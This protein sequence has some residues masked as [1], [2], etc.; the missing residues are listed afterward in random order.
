MPLRNGE[1]QVQLLE[2]HELSLRA[3][4]S[5]TSSGGDI[6]TR[7]NRLMAD[8]SSLQ[9]EFGAFQATFATLAQDVS[10][11]KK[12]MEQI[13]GLRE[14]VHD[15][16]IECQHVQSGL[17]MVQEHADGL[18]E[19]I[20]NLEDETKTIQETLEQFAEDH[21]MAAIVFEHSEDCMGGQRADNQGGNAMMKEH[22]ARLDTEGGRS[23]RLS[24]GPRSRASSGEDEDEEG[25]I[26]EL[27]DGDHT[28]SDV[29]RRAASDRPMARNFRD[30]VLRASV[31]SHSNSVPT[32]IGAIRVLPGFEAF[33]FEFPNWRGK[34]IHLDPGD[35]DLVGAKVGA[36]RLQRLRDSERSIHKDVEDLKATV[37]SYESRFDAARREMHSMIES[38]GNENEDKLMAHIAEIEKKAKHLE[39]LSIQFNADIESLRMTKADRGENMDLPEQVQD[40]KQRFEKLHEFVNGE[41]AKISGKADVSMVIDKVSRDE[42]EEFVDAIQRLLSIGG[43]YAYTGHKPVNLEG[44]AR[45][46]AKEGLHGV[47]NVHFTPLRGSPSL[48]V[49]S[50]HL[51][52]QFGGV[53]R[54]WVDQSSSALGRGV[55][56][57]SGPSRQRTT[58]T[59]QRSSPVKESSQGD[60]SQG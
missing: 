22:V 55:Q 56:L 34:V 23:S 32:H 10:G 24:S 31:S 58:T 21:P 28:L 47:D 11:L 36:V 25:W 57:K 42:I 45:R 59:N 40:L 35:H 50:S 19:R 18:D 17:E 39:S 29:Q 4:V 3:A 13:E 46:Q 15:V 52:R 33:L 9:Q 8:F 44:P 37:E 51:P 43:P 20:L 48:R 41:C 5:T 60:L 7:F 27:P 30:T 12:D 54:Q 14:D 49:W 38:T 26:V 6:L 16:K 2:V 53:E 1:R